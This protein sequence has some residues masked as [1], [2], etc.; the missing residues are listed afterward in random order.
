MSREIYTYSDLTKLSKS[1]T[2]EQIKNFPIITVS[3]DLRK[4]LVGKKEI[5][6]VDGILNKDYNVRIVEFHSFSEAMNLEWNTDQT[7]F[8]QMIL[9]SEYI[10]NKMES[11]KNNI[12]TYNWLLGCMRNM[13]AILSAIILLEQAN[14]RPDQLRGFTDLDFIK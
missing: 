1:K 7:K 2:F 8:A 13:D 5:D 3:S 11:E 4:G 10:R 9:I 14:V 12:K 6:K